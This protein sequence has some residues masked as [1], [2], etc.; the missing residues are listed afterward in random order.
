MVSIEQL[1]T[2]A[3]AARAPIRDAQRITL[4]LEQAMRRMA[5]FRTRDEVDIDVVWQLVHID[6]EHTLVVCLRRLH[7]EAVTVDQQP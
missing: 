3:A 4:Q 1:M 2:H 5:G 6:V 7:A